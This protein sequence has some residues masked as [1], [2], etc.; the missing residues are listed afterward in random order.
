MDHVITMNGEYPLQKLHSPQED[1]VYSPESRGTRQS[2][3]QHG[4]NTLQ[5]QGT[6]EAVVSCD[7]T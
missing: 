5:P 4:S 7:V 3:L 2:M 6:A 1:M